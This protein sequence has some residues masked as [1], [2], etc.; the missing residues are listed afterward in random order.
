MEGHLH[1]YLENGMSTTG[2]QAISWI[3]HKSGNI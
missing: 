1:M 3:T 2:L